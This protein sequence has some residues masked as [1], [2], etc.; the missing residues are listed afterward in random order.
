MNGMSI[1]DDSKIGFPWSRVSSSASSSLF[2][3]TRSAIRLR[4]LPRSAPA[5]FRQSPAVSAAR[6]A[7]TARST[8]S[9]PASAISVRT[10]PVAGLMVGKLRPVEALRHSP[11]MKRRPGFTLAFVGAIMVTR[12]RCKGPR[13]DSPGGGERAGSIFGKSAII[14]RGAPRAGTVEPR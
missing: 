4:I 3:S 2:C 14:A 10:P 11:P 13:R 9:T 8:S 5:I 6:A 7:R 12:S 1:F